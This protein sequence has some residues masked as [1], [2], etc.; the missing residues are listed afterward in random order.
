MVIIALYQNDVQS[1]D[2]TNADYDV[3]MHNKMILR[4]YYTYYLFCL[5]T[6]VDEEQI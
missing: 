6:D 1:G 5:I 2:K 3:K 4:T